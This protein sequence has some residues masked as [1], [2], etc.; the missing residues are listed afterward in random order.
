MGVAEPDD[1]AT[2]VLPIVGDDRG[3]EGSA[4]S[5]ADRA[6]VRRGRR[7]LWI[8]L[9]VG[10]LLVLGVGS[11]YL[12]DLNSTAGRIERG[13]S[14]AGVQ[15]GELTPAEATEL[16]RRELAPRFAAPV[17][18][19]AHGE[20]MAL[21]PAEAG[22][23]ADI[24]AA[25]AAAG[26]RSS[27]P[28][29]R[30]TS[31]SRSVEV[32]LT[33]TVDDGALKAWVS[34]VAAR[35]DVAAVEGEFSRKGLE[36]VVVE[37][38]VG[39]YLQQDEAVSA[40]AAAWRSGNALAL[41]GLEL[42]TSTEPVRVSAKALAAAKVKAETL[43][44]GDLA[45]KTGDGTLTIPAATVAKAVTIREKDDGFAVGIDSAVLRSAVERDVE[46]TERTPKDA[47]LALSDGKP[48]IT[49]GVTGRTV[50][51]D[52]TEAAAGRALMSGK[53]VWTVAYTET[54]PEFSTADAKAYGLTEVIGEFTT[55]GFAYASGQNV[56]VVAEKVQ[57][58][59][60]KPGETFS[61]N[62]FTGQ[63]TEAEGYIPAGVIDNGV[64]GTAVGGGIS[65]FATTLYNA[66]YFA[67]MGDVTHT[68]HSFYISRYPLGREATVYDGQIDLAFSNDYDTAVMIQTVWT[69]SD[70]TVRIW[71]TRHVEVES[72]TGEPFGYTAPETRTVP[73]GQS[74]S[75]SNGS[76]GYSVVNTRIIKD[77][78]GTVIRREPFTTVYNGQVQVICEPAPTP[79]TTAAP[80]ATTGPATTAGGN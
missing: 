19:N 3:D 18:V 34:G 64:I 71:G 23:T 21:D 32:P 56:K 41:D 11:A 79:A 42:P 67:G 66:A 24:D 43:L 54:E 38:V 9:G 39:R 51:W 6:P 26:L 77:L 12:V 61:L 62:T 33:V 58:A 49:P 50:D 69:E 59:L 28:W 7:G 40:I 74:C 31:F 35:T 78:S 36:V 76:S 48:T 13:T 17:T 47:A 15:I 30:L 5:A 80:T 44:D 4:S 75:P 1:D 65:Q 52:A 72:E 22:L 45:V 57:G 27:S 2:T 8:G 60:I 68:P 63:R 53:R 73:Y 70:I 46:T 37:P 10:L 16:L 14:I 29:G 25:V 55:G 20:G